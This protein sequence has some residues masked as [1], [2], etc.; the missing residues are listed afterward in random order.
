[1]VWQQIV[2]GLATNCRL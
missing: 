2:G 1:V